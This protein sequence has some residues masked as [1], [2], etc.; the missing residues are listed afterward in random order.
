[1]G[2]PRIPVELNE[3][4]EWVEQVAGDRH[5]ASSSSV[6]RVAVRLAKH[7]NCKDGV[8]RPGQ[9]AIGKALGLSGPTIRKALDALEARGHIAPRTRA[10]E[11]GAVK[12][13]GCNRYQL[14]LR[15]DDT[16]SE[17][18]PAVLALKARGAILAVEKRKGSYG[19]PKAGSVRALTGPSVSAVTDQSV[20]A[21]TTKHLIETLSET[22]ASAPPPPAAAVAVRPFETFYYPNDRA[23]EAELRQ[24]CRSFAEG[25][26]LARDRNLDPVVRLMNSGRVLAPLIVKIALEDMEAKAEYPVTRWRQTVGWLRAEA[27]HAMP[28]N[29]PP[30]FDEH[31]ER[32]LQVCGTMISERSIMQAVKVWTTSGFWPDHFGAE[33][34]RDTSEVPQ[35]L[36]DRAHQEGVR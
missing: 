19:S 6:L 18:T 30:G 21:L 17:S 31:R 7:F 9:T 28:S 16:D 1:M 25:K 10:A 24:Q 4:S 20:R 23:S 33:P 14:R 36:V 27:A 12:S 8:A 34:G 29:A 32:R 11:V 35:W 26:P 5:L 15:L 13:F 3:K 2:E 22:S